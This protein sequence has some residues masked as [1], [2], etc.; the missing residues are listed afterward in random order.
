MGLARVRRSRETRA[1][2]LLQL[3]RVSGDRGLGIA[4]LIAAQA[5]DLPEQVAYGVIGVLLAGIIAGDRRH[6]ASAAAPTAEPAPSTIDPVEAAELIERCRRAGL[7]PKLV[8]DAVN[9]T[10]GHP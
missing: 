8:A 3:L 5:W 2:D 1:V 9:K 4:A 7:D 10:H 6:T